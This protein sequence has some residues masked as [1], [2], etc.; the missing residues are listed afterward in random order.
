MK[1][2]TT[3]YLIVAAAV[4]LYLYQQAQD[5]KVITAI[6]NSTANL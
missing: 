5:K 3:I 1:G 6:Q 4:A 2:N